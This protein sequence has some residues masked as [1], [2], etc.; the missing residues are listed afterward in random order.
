MQQFI[1]RVKTGGAKSLRFAWAHRSS[2]T[3]LL[4]GVLLP[5]YGFGELA[6]DIWEKEDGFS[7]DKPLLLFIHAHARPQLDALASALTRLGGFWGVTLM[8]TLIALGL[9]MGRQWQ[10]LT[11]FLIAL[12]GNGLINRVTKGLLQRVRPQLWESPAPEFDYGFPSG[13]AMASMGIVAALV[14]LS[15][16]SR[17]RWWVVAVGGLFVS[18]VAWTRLYLGVHYPSDIAAGW[19]A[20]IAWVIGV[21][22]VTRPTARHLAEGTGRGVLPDQTLPNQQQKC[23]VSQGR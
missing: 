23:A 6:E 8:A 7:W 9:L 13:H 4:L 12:I 14:V 20:S 18:T 3:L 1:E 16:Q 17:W 21:W 5:L 15:W 10:R 11:F 19:M 22:L 2:L